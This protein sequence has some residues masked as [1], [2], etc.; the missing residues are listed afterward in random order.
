MIILKLI[1][2][3]FPEVSEYLKASNL[4]CV[5]AILNLIKKEQILE[6]RIFKVCFKFD[7]TYCF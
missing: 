1:L 7:E 5:F 4:K 6:M 3:I 2:L